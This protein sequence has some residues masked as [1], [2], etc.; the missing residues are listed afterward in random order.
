[1]KPRLA[2]LAM[3]L[4]ETMWLKFAHLNLKSSLENRSSKSDFAVS[5]LR[6]FRHLGSPLETL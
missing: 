2:D 5:Q 1:M 3:L 6:K 4:Y